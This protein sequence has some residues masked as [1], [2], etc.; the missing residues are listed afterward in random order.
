MYE[1]RYLEK[2]GYIALWICQGRKLTHTQATEAVKDT[3]LPF[4]TTY[5]AR[6]LLSA[7]TTI[8]TKSRNRLAIHND[9]RIHSL[10]IDN[11]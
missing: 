4:A 11:F 1:K 6:N 9:L 5:F 7:V 8:R 3:I 10:N 2:C